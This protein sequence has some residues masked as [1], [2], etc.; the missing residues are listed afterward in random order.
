MKKAKVIKTKAVE[1]YL[2]IYKEHGLITEIDMLVINKWIECVENCGAIVLQKLTDQR[3]LK[4]RET[5]EAVLDKPIVENYELLFFRDHALSYEWKGFRSS[6][7]LGAGRI[8]YR[9]LKDKIE[10]VEIHSITENHN[11]KRSKK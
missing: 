6:T 1:L 7:F 3:E 5:Q 8:I 10:I 9:V 4:N 11:Y 2:K